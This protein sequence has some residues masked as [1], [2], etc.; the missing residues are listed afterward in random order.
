MVTVGSKSRQ[1]SVEDAQLRD[2]VASSVCTDIEAFIDWHAIHV[3]IV[4][5]RAVSS[6]AGV[7]RLHIA[8]RPAK[9]V[10]GAHTTERFALMGSEGQ[11]CS[12]KCYCVIFEPVYRLHTWWAKMHS[13]QCQNCGIA[14]DRKCDG[15]QKEH[16]CS[17]QCQLL[18]WDQH[19][20]SC[21]R[22]NACGFASGDYRCNCGC[23]RWCSA[24][25]CMNNWD[26]HSVKCTGIRYKTEIDSM[27][28][29][30]SSGKLSYG[31]CAMRISSL[32]LAWQHSSTENMSHVPTPYTTNKSV[33]ETVLAIRSRN[34][35][36]S[37]PK[38]WTV[39]WARTGIQVKRPPPVRLYTPGGK[40]L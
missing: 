17:S 3:R 20:E 31:D 19:R 7:E 15:C 4:P 24:D 38:G 32:M 22:C 10:H 1:L 11:K 30:F 23:G 28:W 8:V 2:T 35:P 6:L 33:P 36:S 18:D 40:R 39:E 13:P 9:K 12:T 14:T 26:N 27:Q 34:T 21:N 37:Q 25:C 5:L 16:Y 29:L